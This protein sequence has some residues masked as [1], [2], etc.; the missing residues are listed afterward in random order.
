MY[1]GGKTDFQEYAELVMQQDFRWNTG[2]E[3]ALA[4]S[5]IKIPTEGDFMAI[6]KVHD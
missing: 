2:N 5:N 4:I 1:V 3:S 6:L